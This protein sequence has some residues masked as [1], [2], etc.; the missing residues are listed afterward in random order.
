MALR[1]D[2]QMSSSQLLLSAE[3][4]RDL[5]F[6]AGGSRFKTVRG[7]T[8][9]SDTIALACMAVLAADYPV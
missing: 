9:T 5:G 7:M 2:V 8:W 1:R 4:L 3:A 6:P